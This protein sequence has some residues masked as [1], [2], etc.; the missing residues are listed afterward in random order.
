M[1]NLNG[2]NLKDFNREENKASTLQDILCKIY[3]LPFHSIFRTLRSFS[4]ASVHTFYEHSIGSTHLETVPLSPKF[5]LELQ[6]KIKNCP[7]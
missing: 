5:G 2:K 3:K 6:N 7:L 4:I 1:F